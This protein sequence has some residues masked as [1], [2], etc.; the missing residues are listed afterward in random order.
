MGPGVHEW[1]VENISS[2]YTRAFTSH[3][4]AVAWLTREALTVRPGSDVFPASSDDEAL[5][6][7]AGNSERSNAGADP[8]AAE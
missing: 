7:E 8:H 4:E 6:G 3:E 5:V 1:R 2:R